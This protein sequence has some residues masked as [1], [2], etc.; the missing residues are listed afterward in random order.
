MIRYRRTS[1]PALL[2]SALLA[3]ASLAPIAASGQ[4]SLTANRPSTPGDHTFGDLETVA[5]FTGPMPTGVT[6]SRSGRIFVNFPRWG[7]DVPFT[8]AELVHGKAVAF[9]NPQMNDWP[10]RS[11]P[12]P[13]A[14]GRNSQEEQANQ[15]H[16][17]NVQSVVVDASGGSQGEGRLWALDTGAP[18]LKNIVPG[19]PKLV[20][21]DLA[22]NTVVKTILLPPETAGANTYLNDI[23]FD[24]TVG[25]RGP[26]DPQT[27]IGSRPAADPTKPAPDP[28]HPSAERSAG[29]PTGTSDIHGTAYI[30]DSSSDGPNAIIVVDLA[31]GKSR[32][33]LNQ[34]SSVLSEDQFLMFAE[35]RPV[36]QTSPGS[37]PKAVNFAADGIAI[38]NDGKTLYYCPINGTRLYAVSTDLLRDRSKSDAQVAATVRIVTGKMPSDGLESDAEGNVYMSDPVTDSIHRFNPATG[39]TETLVHDPRLLWPDTMSLA[40]DGYLYVTANQLNRQPTMHNGQDLRVKPYTLFRLK[41]NARPVRLM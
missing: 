31:T 7:D 15:T 1:T 33:R 41:V 11:L 12:N 36:Y 13:N 26:Q 38:S 30:T 34:H 9:P 25:D 3:A 22:T 35:G 19:G 16:F 18:L 29:Q 6:V 8:V 17:V 24:L 5:T 21:I 28:M 37:P 20:C 40:D 2:A 23:R 4:S 14:F 39:L 27:M 32:R 10:G